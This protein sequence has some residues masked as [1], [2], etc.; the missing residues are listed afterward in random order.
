MSTPSSRERDD[1]GRRTFLKGVAAGA[2]GLGLA[3][4]F[5]R[6][7]LGEEETAPAGG[8]MKTRVLGRTKVPVSVVAYGG[9]G[10]TPDAVRLLQVAVEKGVNFI[11]VAHSYGGGKAEEAVG[12][13]LQGYAH[14][15]KLFINTKLSSFT[16]PQGS[17]KQVYDQFEERVRTSLE[18]MKTDYLDLVMW[19]HGAQDLDFLKHEAARDALRKLQEKGLVRFFGTSSHQNYTAVCEAVVDDGFYDV[20]LT[21]INICTQNQAEAGQAQPGRG[22]RQRGRPIEDTTA[23]LKKAKAKNVGVMAMKVANGGYL[24]SGTDALLA[25]AFPGESA[26]SRHQKLYRYALDQAGVCVD[27]VGIRSALHLKEAIELGCA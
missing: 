5:P 10:L 18:R 21:V 11:D 2:V 24:G 8:T 12:A 20:F 23:L 9:G 26:L 15:D 25:K 6:D 27:V 14:R 13:F 4:A 17:A 1:L 7:V 16:N 3:G 22:G 19:P